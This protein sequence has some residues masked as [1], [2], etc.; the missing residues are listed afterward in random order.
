M[1]GTKREG[2]PGHQDTRDL[3]PWERMTWCAYT[4]M[5]VSRYG[6]HFHPPLPLGFS[7]QKCTTILVWSKHD[8]KLND[9]CSNSGQNWPNHKYIQYTTYMGS[10]QLFLSF[11]SRT[12]Q[13]VSIVCTP[14]P[15]AAGG[16]FW[17]FQNLLFRGMM[18]EQFRG[19]LPY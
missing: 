4:S 8:L 19:D 14:S 3:T 10:M 12:F 17:S 11:G 18:Y 7:I 15:Q 16:D 13:E 6:A 1:M 5:Y 2:I 9:N